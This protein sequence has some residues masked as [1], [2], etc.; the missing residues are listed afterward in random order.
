V[1][2]GHETGL[3]PAVGVPPDT[4]C[5][6]GL[7]ADQ[8]VVRV[9]YAGP[10][11]TDRVGHIE[12]HRSVVGDVASFFALAYALRFPIE[13]VVQA[14]ELAWDDPRLMAENCTSGFNFRTVAG[15]DVLSLHALG[16]AFDVNTRLNPYIRVGAGGEHKVEPAGARYDPA[17][18][19]TLDDGHALVDH[20]LD[21]GWRWGGH[22]SL[23]RD[24]VV[25]YQHFENR[26]P[27]AE[28]RRLLSSYGLPVSGVA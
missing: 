6:P 21:R 10:D 12:V 27:A 4:A 19:G 17:V 16:L 5:P 8:R 25:D 14:G 26:P 22:W 18:P 3:T 2:S 24:G 13:R 9:R 15:R 11:G 28:L 20:L 1:N 7:V 23:E